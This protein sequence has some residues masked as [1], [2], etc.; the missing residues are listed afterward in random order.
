VSHG[1][2]ALFPVMPYPDFRKMSD[3]D[4]ASVVVYLRSFPPVRKQRPVTNFR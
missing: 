3:E 4:L 1:G 2:R